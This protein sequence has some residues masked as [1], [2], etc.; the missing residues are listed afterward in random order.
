MDYLTKHPKL[1]Q[2]GALI[3]VFFI[4]M[5]MTGEY[6]GYLELR[7]GFS[8]KV[9]SGEIKA[10]ASFSDSV[11]MILRG[12]LPPQFIRIPEMHFYNP[13]I[14]SSIGYLLTMLFIIAGL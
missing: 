6:A 4:L 3:I 14:S 7:D 13:V 12:Q 1:V 10:V 8:N 9:E 11:S 2:F 5:S